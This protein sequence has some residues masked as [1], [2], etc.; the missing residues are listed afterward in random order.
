M[1]CCVRA[2]L[3]THRSLACT[4]LGPRAAACMSSRR[5]AGTRCKVDPK[6]LSLHYFVVSRGPRNSEHTVLAEQQTRRKD[7]LC[8][9]RCTVKMHPGGRCRFLTT[10]QPPT[11]P[12]HH[13]DLCSSGPRSHIAPKTLLQSHCHPL[14]RRK[15]APIKAQALAP[16]FHALHDIPRPRHRWCDLIRA[17]PSTPSRL[18]RQ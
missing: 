8:S 13:E 7:F 17:P 9:S 4:E 2:G 3:T 15:K 1:C 16:V 10:P 11:P 14:D 5:G 12:L 6:K 18:H